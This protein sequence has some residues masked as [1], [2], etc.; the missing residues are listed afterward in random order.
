MMDGRSA[1]L[2]AISLLIGSAAAGMT[3]KFSANDV[4]R[5]PSDFDFARTG[6]GRE[7]QWALVG[8]DTAAAG[9]ALEQKS[10]DATDYRFPLAIYLH[11]TAANVT[12]SVRFKPIS[13]K[14]DKAGGIAVRLVDA[15]N[16]YVVR[17]N[18]LENNVRFYRVVN[19]RRDQLASS[20]R[21]VKANEWH[22]LSVRAEG[23]RFTILYDG[24]EL[25]R[26]SDATFGG[27]GRVALWTKADSVTRFDA[28]QIEPRD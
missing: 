5:P 14:I 20:D 2:V 3:V 19:G 10:V 22:S 21:R 7:G 23:G 4:G 25:Y 6:E 9:V 28:L 17:A 18:A 24:E 15:N 8:D 11:A 27:P 16:Y 12:V 1:V 26:V 13:G